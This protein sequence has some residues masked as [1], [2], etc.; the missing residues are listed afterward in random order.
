M[1]PHSASFL[2]EKS[3][4]RRELCRILHK[5]CNILGCLEEYGITDDENIATNEAKAKAILVRLGII[6][7]G[8]VK[9]VTSL[10]CGFNKIY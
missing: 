2:Q 6:E 10:L 3:I 1:Q 7:I 4:R 8:T 5:N 9:R